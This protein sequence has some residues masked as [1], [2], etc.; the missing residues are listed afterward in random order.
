MLLEFGKSFRLGNTALKQCSDRGDGLR[1]VYIDV[2]SWASQ[3]SWLLLI[4][5]IL[6]RD[7]KV[8]SA[9]QDNIRRMALIFPTSSPPLWRAE[10]VWHILRSQFKRNA[11]SRANILFVNDMRASAHE[12]CEFL[13]RAVDGITS[14]RK[15]YSTCRETESFGALNNLSDSKLFFAWLV[16][17]RPGW[18]WHVGNVT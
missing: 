7:S 10:W 4:K 1:Y 16:S 3:D 14:Q 13:R 8:P 17:V 18:S 9:R 11:L 6:I 5:A 2:H 12:K 15:L